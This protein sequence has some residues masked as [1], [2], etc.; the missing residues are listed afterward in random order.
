MRFASGRDSG[1]QTL[2]SANGYKAKIPLVGQ[3]QVWQKQKLSV[4]GGDQVSV[5]TDDICFLSE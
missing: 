2:A 5:E 3:G 1:R 4:R